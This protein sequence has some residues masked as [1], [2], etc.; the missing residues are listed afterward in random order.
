ML[1]DLESYHKSVAS[2]ID[3]GYYLGSLIILVEDGQ[4]KNIDSEWNLLDGQQRITTLSLLLTEIYKRLQLYDDARGAKKVLR[5]IKQ[6]WMELRDGQ[7][8]PEEDWKWA[9]YPRRDEDRK[10]LRDILD[11]NDLSEIDHGGNML[12]AAIE[13]NTRVS[14]FDPEELI[15]L[16]TTVLE[17]VQ[18]SVIITDESTMAYQMF[19]TA[20]ARGTP[21]TSLDLFRS[22]VIKRAETEL[23]V[24]GEKLDNIMRELDQ[25]EKAVSYAA[26][27]IAEITPQQ[28]KLTPND[29]SKKK[30]TEK[31][32]EK[33]TKDL[34][35]AWV[36]CRSGRILSKGLLPFITSE[37]NHCPDGMALHN[38]VSDLRQHAL[39]WAF[40]IE[41]TPVNRARE[42]PF[43]P[44]FNIV[45]DQWR[46]LALGVRNLSQN[47]SENS[48][49]TQEQ[50]EKI[51]MMQTWWSLA[52]FAQTN[53][54]NTTAFR[55]W[56]LEANMS[57]L[58]SNCSPEGGTKAWNQESFKERCDA[59]LEGLNFDL[60][61]EPYTAVK[62]SDQA[63]KANDA[64]AILS[65]F[66]ILAEE[67]LGSPGLGPIMNGSQTKDA[68]IVPLFSERQVGSPAYYKIGN[69]FLL[70]GTA[71]S[72]LTSNK[73]K[74]IFSNAYTTKAGE[75]RVKTVKEYASLASTMKLPTW[76]DGTVRHQ[77]FINERSIEIRDVLNEALE[78]FIITGWP[79]GDVS[80]LQ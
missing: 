67:L 60:L 23:E 48:P 36:G 4:T 6:D 33:I 61:W 39:T 20:N 51:Q 45:K 66:E 7:D 37:I 77:T 11:H 25:I 13:F 72:G 18:V 24:S 27:G 52:E 30:K 70:R 57:W 58:H 41:R 2:G 28:G 9:L 21:L 68:R 43:Q 55:E 71:K 26:G 42:D 3:Y 76:Y 73:V 32:K 34:M 1:E 62:V 53:K 16:S 50:M 64:R 40:Q 69:W 63:D 75:K 74:E 29:K 5:R 54:I 10:A 31:K 38:L 80:P 56:A 59:R 15:Q 49:I 65:M 12:E 35:M 22:T 78:N 17:R 8:P 14:A 47:A 79:P 44:M 19:Q 46:W